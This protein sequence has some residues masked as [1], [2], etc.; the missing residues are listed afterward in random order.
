MVSRLEFNFTN[1][2]SCSYFTATVLGPRTFFYFYIPL[3]AP[4]S[5]FDTLELNQIR[6]SAIEE[7][8]MNPDGYGG[9]L[10]K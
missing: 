9:P 10:S 8:L 5:I 1:Y 7:I 6:C 3:K 2:N 4:N